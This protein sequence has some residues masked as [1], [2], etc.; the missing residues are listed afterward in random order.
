MFAAHSL[1]LF[2]FFA[3]PF[4]AFAHID[5]ATGQDYQGYERRDG[6]GSCCDWHDCRPAT[7]PFP[8]KDGERIRDRAG[9]EFAFDPG[10]V[11]GRPSDDG[12][13]HV[14]GDGRRLKCIIAP[15]QAG[16][17]SGPATT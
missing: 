13:W 9:N 16:L 11:V 1:P 4:A 6:K 17:L 5:R 8:S 2:A 10:K 12:N 7:T 14:C 15:A 3:L